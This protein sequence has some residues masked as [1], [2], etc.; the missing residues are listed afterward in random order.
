ML[1]P[2]NVAYLF[3][4]ARAKQWLTRKREPRQS[5]LFPLT[6]ADKPTRDFDPSKFAYALD[7]RTL[8]ITERLS[9]RLTEEFPRDTTPEGFAGP[10]AVPG[11]FYAVRSVSGYGMDPLPLPLMDN[12]PFV[13]SLGLRDSIRHE[14][15]PWLKSLIRLFFGH[16]T[17]ASLHIR[18]AAST[19]FP[20][21]E[22]DR[23]QETRHNESLT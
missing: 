11:N 9:V 18:K 7:P 21:F 4:P 15:I 23:L 20:Y 22:K 19:S 13:K 2:D 3:K 6:Y 12:G 17:P 14:D 5:A 10:S 1:I 16:V 8:R